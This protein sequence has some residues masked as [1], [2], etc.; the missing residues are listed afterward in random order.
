MSPLDTEMREHFFGSAGGAV[1]DFLPGVSLTGS[2][3]D[4]LRAI[5]EAIRRMQRLRAQIARGST[6]LPPGELYGPHINAP[7]WP[8]FVAGWL[9]GALFVAMFVVAWI[10]S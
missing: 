4:K 5:D 1:P 3:D 6:A 9:V 8:W 10:Y 2:P 7:V